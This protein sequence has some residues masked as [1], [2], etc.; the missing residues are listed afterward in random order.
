MR[1]I[2]PTAQQPVDDAMAKTG[3][4]YARFM[5]SLG[6]AGDDPTRS[7][8]ARS[9]RVCGRLFRND[10]VDAISD[11]PKIRHER[12][13]LATPFADVPGRPEDRIQLL[14]DVRPFR[15]RF[16]KPIWPAAT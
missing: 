14:T 3:L 10:A 1:A 15:Q 13:V 6:G 8:R 7:R 5:D 9:R 12:R 16:R 2:G 4:F 11:G